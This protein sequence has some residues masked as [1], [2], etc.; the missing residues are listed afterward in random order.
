[1]EEGRNGPHS[2]LTLPTKFPKP[3]SKFFNRN[4]GQRKDDEGNDRQFPIAV[5]DDPDQPKDGESIFEKTGD[6]IGNRSLNQVDIIGDPG[7]EDASRRFSKE[8]EG[9]GLEMIVEFLPDIRD[10]SQTHKVHQVSL[11]VIEGPFD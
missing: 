3:L 4:D 2:L 9:K 5:E 8:G 6:S 11:A 7:N 10:N 1:M